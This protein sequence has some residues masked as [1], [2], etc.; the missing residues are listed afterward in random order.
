[1]RGRTRVRLLAGTA[2]FVAATLAFGAR[3]ADAA[4]DAY[5]ASIQLAPS[6]SLTCGNDW[7]S[8]ATWSCQTPTPLV[9]GGIGCIQSTYVDVDNRSVSVPLTGCTATLNVPSGG[10]SGSDTCN[11]SVPLGTHCVGTLADGFAE[12]SFRPALGEAVVDAPAAI[13]DAQ[14]TDNGGR[15]TVESTGLVDGNPFSMSSTLT[16]VG[17]CTSVSTLTW[18]GTVTFA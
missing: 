17:S 11:R 4:T 2:A 1:M 12:F 10:W 6:G 3:P 18:T 15:A 14:C 8:G 5:T 13:T 16:W 9:A 7:P